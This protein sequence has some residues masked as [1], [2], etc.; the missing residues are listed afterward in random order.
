[1]NEKNLN[2]VEQHKSTIPPPARPPAKK[3]AAVPP[4]GR[5]NS[6]SKELDS[7]TDEDDNSK[8]ITNSENSGTFSYN[9]TPLPP[10]RQGYKEKNKDLAIKL[11]KQK[12]EMEKEKGNEKEGYLKRR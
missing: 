8:L 11:A 4:K 3:P 1:M 6:S 12:E 7:S 2:E 10:Y 9:Y 5:P